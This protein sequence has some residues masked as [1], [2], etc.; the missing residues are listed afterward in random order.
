MA[1]STTAFLTSLTDA[2]PTSNKA[3]I[4]SE[5][6]KTKGYSAD[7]VKLLGFERDGKFNFYFFQVPGAV[8]EIEIFWDA[9]K[10]KYERR[11]SDVIDDPTEVREML[12]YLPD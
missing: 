7:K 1:S 12:G 3:R 10:S 5:L 6:I 11:F 9:D 2:D 4:V 8:V